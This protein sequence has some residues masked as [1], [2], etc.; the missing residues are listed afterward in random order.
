M[1]DEPLGGDSIFVLDEEAA[2]TASQTRAT[3]TPMSPPRDVALRVGHRLPVPMTM[4]LRR[5]RLRCFTASRG[6]R[7]RGWR[8]YQVV[9]GFGPR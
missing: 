6:R 4:V 1:I 7:R 5:R 9:G 2:V 8:W 3:G